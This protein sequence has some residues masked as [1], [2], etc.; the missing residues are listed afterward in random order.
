MNVRTVVSVVVALLVV[1]SVLVLP[2]TASVGGEPN[3]SVTVAD[4]RLDPGDAT[5]L[6]LSIQNRGELNYS[7]NPQLDDRATTARAV[8]VQAT[9][10]GDAPIDVQTSTQ[11]VGSIRDGSLTQVPIQVVVDEDAAP[12]TYDLDVELEY[13]YFRNYDNNG[14]IVQQTVERERTVELRVR[15]R[16]R[17]DIALVDSDVAIGDSGPV[18]VAV[19]NRGDQTAEN[20][21]L[22]LTS[23]N[24]GLTLGGNPTAQTHLD[25]LAPGERRN[26]TVEGAVAEGGQQRNYSV[27]ATI[28]YEDQDGLEASSTDHRFGVRPAP[29]RSFA[30]EGVESDL[31]VDEERT[32][33]GQLRNDGAGAVD[34]VVL[35]LETTNPNIDVSEPEIALGSLEAGESADFSFDVG[36]SD[37]AEPGDRQFTLTAEYRTQ[38]DDRRTSDPLDAQVS[39][40]ERRPAFEVTG[41]NA[42]YTAGSGGI[43]EIEIRNARDRSVTDVSAKLYTN[44]P[45][46]SGDDEAFVER[47]D[48]G[49]TRTITFALQVGG[50]ALPKVYP[51]QVD[52]QYDDA[53]GDTHITDTYQVPVTVNEPDN[54]GLP[55]VPIVIGV[56]LVVAATAGYAYYRR[57]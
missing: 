50:A 56:V 5:A 41:V 12:G 14:P 49:E 35:R 15:S 30:I 29:E 13:T 55:L 8:S 1:G 44:A 10:D 16:P 2:A 57:R 22:E 23:D 26:V 28:D 3:L 31:R 7:S 46:S 24:P 27:S 17:F 40:A 6:E 43:L 38:A 33:S 47:L 53:D 54:G 37:N 21:R 32:V 20:A 34:N 19:T 9:T 25:N 39:I 42:S 45:L 4:D 51:A 52:F 18:T 11:S 48:S 36:V